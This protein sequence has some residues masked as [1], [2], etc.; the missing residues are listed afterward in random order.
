M[1][2]DNCFITWRFTPTQNDLETVYKIFLKYRKG[3]NNAYLSNYHDIPDFEIFPKE[4]LN[5]EKQTEANIARS[6]YFSGVAIVIDKEE[7]GD[8]HFYYFEDN[9]ENQVIF[10][11]EDLFDKN[12]E[13]IL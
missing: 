13:I 1:F 11:N 4:A 10:A 3:Y 7:N 5:K 9:L 2:K 12:G 6:I 8:Y